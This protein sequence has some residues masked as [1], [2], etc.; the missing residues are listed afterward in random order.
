MSQAL[1]EGMILLLLAAA[2]GVF[3]L[4]EIALVSSRPAR[5]ERLGQAGS[6]G[7]K[8]ALGL[9]QTPGR[10]L[11]TVQV[12]ITLVGVLSGAFGGATLGV[13]L[14]AQLAQ[15]PALARYSHLLG[16]GSVVIATT[17]LSLII[18]ELVPKRLALSD[19]E[20]YAARIARLMELL[21]RV[22]GPIVRFLDASTEAV[23][24]LVGKRAE[25]R[26][27]VDEG[28]IMAMLRRGREAGT[29]EPVEQELIERVFR[30]ADRRLGSMLTPRPDITWLDVEA[31]DEE[32]RARVVQSIHARFP[33]CRGSLDDVLGVVHTK[34]LLALQL[35]GGPFDLSRVVRQPKFVPE[36]TSAL[37]VLEAFK[38]AGMH[39]ALVMDEYGGLEGLVTTNDVL[40][41]LVGEIP[42]TG[43]SDDFE[44]RQQ[45]TDRWLADGMLPIEEL[46]EAI[47]LPDLPGEERGVYQ[48]IGGFVMMHQARIPRVGDAFDWG[49]F[50]F[51]VRAMEGL[52]VD[53]VLIERIE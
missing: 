25:R 33:V 22:A 36:S 6:A 11:S 5:L 45:G 41:A 35:A 15:V 27:P 34:D 29:F 40:E 24:A 17:Y 4:S 42:V 18:G 30:L 7:A 47:D 46:K 50:H 2:N 20:R 23:M 12:G 49:G 9:A 48:T 31:S 38:A 26:P 21:A 19:P 51:E 37:A 39:I 52:R 53:K 13:R 3:A 14:S 32:N 10:F 28:E 44:V 8:I 43:E 16:V 1:L